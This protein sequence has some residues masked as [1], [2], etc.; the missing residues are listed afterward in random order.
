MALSQFGNDLTMSTATLEQT[1]ENHAAL[2]A[3]NLALGP[4]LNKS[5]Y[6]KIIDHGNGHKIAALLRSHKQNKK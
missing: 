3:I 5:L 6:T 4:K 1:L 2:K